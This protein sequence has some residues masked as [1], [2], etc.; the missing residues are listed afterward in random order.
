MF[1]DIVL[2]LTSLPKKTFKQKSHD[3]NLKYTAHNIV[4]NVTTSWYVGSTK[5]D[6]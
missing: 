1:L 5:K 6:F 4:H 3:A 2:H